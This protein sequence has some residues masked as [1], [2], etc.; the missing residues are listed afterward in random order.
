MERNCVKF[1]TS[2]IIIYGSNNTQ[3]LFTIHQRAWW[4]CEK[5]IDQ[6]N[7]LVTQVM[8][9]WYNSGA[10]YVFH[11]FWLSQY[12]HHE[13]TLWRL[14]LVK[15]NAAFANRDLINAFFDCKTCVMFLHFQRE[16]MSMLKVLSL[17]HT[18]RVQQIYKRTTV[19]SKFLKNE[20]HASSPDEKALVEACK[21]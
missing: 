6:F 19:S 3:N 13:V 20:Y 7:L 2:N 11:M 5:L 21:R 16:L 12:C 14:C 9:H 8:T 10:E 18:C 15:A 1:K 17:C 4:Q